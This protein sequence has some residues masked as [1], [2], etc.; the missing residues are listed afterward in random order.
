M[1]QSNDQDVARLR[2]RISQ[3][4]FEASRRDVI[5]RI[6]TVIL[7]LSDDDYEAV[8]EAI[9]EALA[10]LGVSY[11]DCCVH[12]VEHDQKITQCMRSSSGWTRLSVQSDNWQLIRRFQPGSAPIYR[13][14]LTR[15]DPFAEA[16]WALTRTPPSVVS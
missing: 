16:T 6:R 5:D 15:D 1:E 10:E 14:D 11:D 3:L 9:V 4:E 12:V 13:P 8:L 7:G 2:E